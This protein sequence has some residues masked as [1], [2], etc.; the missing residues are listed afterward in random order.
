MESEFEKIQ[1][2]AMRRLQELGAQD[3][4][5]VLAQKG[6][7]PMI[8]CEAAC[9]LEDRILASELVSKNICAAFSDERMRDTSDCSSD[10][11]RWKDWIT[12]VQSEETVLAAYRASKGRQKIR[13]DLP[14][15]IVA[16]HRDIL[17]QIIIGVEDCWS[18][19]KPFM[20]GFVGTHEEWRAI[21]EKVR[22]KEVIEM[23]VR[24]FSAEDED[25]LLRLAQ[26]GHDCAAQRLVNIDPLKYAERYVDRLDLSTLD[27]STMKKVVNNKCLSQE[28][29][30]KIALSYYIGGD[31]AHLALNCLT[32]QNLLGHLLL[33]KEIHGYYIKES[34]CR[35]W[36][37]RL[38][39]KIPNQTDVL[40]EYILQ[41]GEN[42]N[43]DV[44]DQALAYITD[45]EQ[46]F[47][48]A[49]SDSIV[50]WKAAQRLAPE[51]M[52]RLEK[53][54]TDAKVIQY[55]GEQ[56]RHLRIA[57]ADDEE[58]LEICLSEER[59]DFAYQ[60]LRELI[61]GSPLEDRLVSETMKRPDKFLCLSAYFGISVGEA[62]WK[63]GGEAYIQ[64]LMTA[65]KNETD[66]HRSRRIVSE[67]AQIY[68][69]V[70]ESKTLI[71]SMQGMRDQRHIDEPE[72]CSIG[73]YVDFVVD[74]EKK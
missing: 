31:V 7:T 62:T 22:C 35:D 19:K 29:L 34:I 28:A 3:R 45:S 54:A 1:V 27:R 72:Y 59:N 37:V 60:R 53:E 58:L 68:R 71:G 50:A 21:A 73:R 67:L 52:L 15:V 12:A 43:R 4:L 9:C 69:N 13:R 64:E 17:P 14:K 26:E 55:A 36:L 63:Y 11:Y 65:L 2:A 48:I 38:I 24:R 40:T 46:L 20:K 49:A 56:W 6:T 23:A 74:L 30:E 25:L 57:S 70:P 33:N 8:R 44:L 32:D 39:E 61:G 47:R 41:S 51:V 5:L 16:A 10:G 42:Y 18:E 66:W